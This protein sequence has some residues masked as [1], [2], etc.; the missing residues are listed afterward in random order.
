MIDSLVP[1]FLNKIDDLVFVQAPH[2]HTVHLTMLVT[3]RILSFEKL[4]WTNLNKV[5]AKI[6]VWTAKKSP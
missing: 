2:D 3:R 1:G 6:I 5:Q 4:L